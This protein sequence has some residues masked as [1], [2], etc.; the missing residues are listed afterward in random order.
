MIDLEVREGDSHEFLHLASRLIAG[1]AVASDLPSMGE[2]RVMTL[3]RGGVSKTEVV[4]IFVVLA[5]LL[6]LSVP[7]IQV[8]RESARRT[9]C[10]RGLATLGIGLSAAEN[11]EGAFPAGTV[12]N[13]Q[14]PPEK[15]L[16][17]YAGASPFLLGQEYLV[18]KMAEMDK[19]K[20]ARQWRQ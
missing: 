18:M 10:K 20:G 11:R 14:L 7:A 16:S 13:I 17:W 9:D 2:G 6:A 19:P 4:V 5:I 12:A 3:P 15:R 1:A 8:A